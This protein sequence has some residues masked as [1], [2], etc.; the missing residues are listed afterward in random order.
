VIESNFP[1][2]SATDAT[3]EIECE[4]SHAERH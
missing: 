1:Q 3:Q 4:E 2:K